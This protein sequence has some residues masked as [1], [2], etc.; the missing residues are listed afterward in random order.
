LKEIKLNFRAFEWLSFHHVL[1]ELNSKADELSK[2]ALELQKGAFGF[3]EF[4]EGEETEAME[5]I[6]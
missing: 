2:E 5:F 6:L 3:Y 1:R 4:F